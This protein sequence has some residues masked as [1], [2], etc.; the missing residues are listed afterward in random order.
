MTSKKMSTAC[1]Y[2]PYP[3]PPLPHTV[4][5]NTVYIFGKS[6]PLK[7]YFRGTLEKP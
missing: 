5:I 7:T 2:A 4:I 3:H 1:A 6:K